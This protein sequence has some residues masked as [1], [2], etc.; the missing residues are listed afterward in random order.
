MRLQRTQWIPCPLPEVFGFFSDAANLEAITSAWLDFRILTPPPIPMR[1]GAVI[2]YRLAWRFI[3]IR[4]KNGDRELEST[5]R[6]RG[7]AGVR[8]LSRLAPHPHVHPRAWRNAHWR[9]V[10]YELPF[11]WLG[12]LA[13]KLRVRRDLERIFDYRAAAI[14]R[15]FGRAVA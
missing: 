9:H 11:G 1:P 8:P 14:E 2:E 5:A 3:G 6:L 4:W 10:E 15:R 7:R 13:H 12:R